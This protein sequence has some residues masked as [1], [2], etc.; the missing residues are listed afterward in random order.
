[1]TTAS[2][3]SISVV[4][5]VRNR[6]HLVGHSL[7]SVLDASRGVVEQG[8]QVEVIVTDDAST[9]GTS[10]VVAS[11]QRTSPIPFRVLRFDTR[12]GPARA[13]NAALDV[14]V[15]DL[16]VFV[17]SDVIVPEGF[18]KAHLEAH[19]KQGPQIYVMGALVWVTTV[20]E[21]LRHPQPTIWDFSSRSLGTANASVRR[22]HLEAVGGFDPAF[23]GM[24]W[25]DSD[26]GRRLQKFGLKR[27]LVQEAVA[28]HVEPVITTQEQLAA[29][30]EKE[31]ERG[32]F[33]V[34]YLAKH[35]EFRT[36]LS[37]QA[38]PVHRL[39]SWLFRMGGL[40]H[41][42]NVLQWM[43]WARKRQRKTLEKIWFEGVITKV[44]L[45]SLRAAMADARAGK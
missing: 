41:E 35:P 1:M 15:G 34:H 26:L 5:P 9:D 29:R 25:E 36:R 6:A 8:V 23:L 45:E 18:F 44:Y 16:V 11:A 38:T 2:V 42:G 21:A 14:A 37:A 39:L 7:K 33:A 17:D 40:V 4:M 30:L 24:G 43:D 13:R 28:Y 3:T 31:R 12:Q 19:A 20:E 10:D 22:E 32:M 27:C